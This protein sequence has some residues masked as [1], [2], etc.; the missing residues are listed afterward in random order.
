MVS[1]ARLLR[2]FAHD[3]RTNVRKLRKLPVF[4]SNPALDPKAP[5]FTRR[6]VNLADARLGA[7]A[8]EASDEFFAPKERMLSPEPPIFIPGKYDD[9]GKWMDG[10]E[11]RRRREPG[12]D[13]C[14]V[15]LARLGAIQGV[16]LDT[17]HFAGNYPGPPLQLMPAAW[18]MAIRT[19]IPNG[20]KWFR[21][22][23]CKGTVIITWMSFPR[24]RSF[25]CGLTFTPT[26]DS[27]GFA[28][29]GGRGPAGTAARKM[30][31]PIWL[32][33]S[34]GLTL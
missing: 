34:M 5:E 20:F 26:A 29:M 15:K 21:R 18:T 2:A 11:T 14:I 6:L 27:P 22:Q 19:R 17:T 9:N 8:V 4:V 25:R 10:W 7:F 28:C 1:G 32:Q 24:A 3:K 16:D 30:P 12:H 31:W 33:W 13:W 23:L